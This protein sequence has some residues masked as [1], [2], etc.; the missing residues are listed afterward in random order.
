M[1]SRTLQ[2]IHQFS[3]DANA[4]FSNAYIIEGIR[5]LVIIDSTLAVSTSRAL[6]EK[7]DSIKKPVSAVLITHGHPDHYNGVIELIKGTK[8]P[9]IASSG[10]DKVIRDSDTDKEKQW[11]PVFKDEW[12]S[13]R[14][15]PSEIIKSGEKLSVD[16]MTFTNH[17]LGPGESHSDSYWLLEADETK[18]AFIGDVVL[19]GVHAYLSDGHSIEWLKNIDKLKQELKSISTIYPGHGEPGD[20]SLLDWQKSYILKYHEVIKKLANGKPS[21][22]DDQKNELQKEMTSYLP[23]DK[24]S[25]L[26]QLGAD[27]V[28]RELSS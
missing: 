10:V 23:T 8:I 19:N 22:T 5:S 27:A 7:A 13:K 17:D 20:L 3:T 1:D 6:K 28:A 4:I 9:V 26:I 18:Y 12:P 15:F 2:K 25:F 16:G 21:L 11:K 24:L 14:A